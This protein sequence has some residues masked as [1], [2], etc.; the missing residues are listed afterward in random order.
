MVVHHPL[1]QLLGY[2]EEHA[3]L[4]SRI[5]TDFDYVLLTGDLN[6]YSDNL[7]DPATSEFV[8]FLS[9]FDLP[10]HATGST[11]KHGQMLYHIEILITTV[12]SSGYP[13]TL[14]T[15]NKTDKAIIIKCY[16]TNDT[17]VTFSDLI[18]SVPPLTHSSCDS[19]VLCQALLNAST[20]LPY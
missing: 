9:S 11:P 10:L 12:S 19:L 14:Y 13:C 1:K 16:F 2:L 15:S 4:L 6:I 8:R 7:V 18:S 5:L 3:E 20:P 17:V